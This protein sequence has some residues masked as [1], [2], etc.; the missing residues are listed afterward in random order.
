MEG[1]KVLSLS[2]IGSFLCNSL[3]C[4]GSCHSDKLYVTDNSLHGVECKRIS[5][6]VFIVNMNMLFFYFMRCKDQSYSKQ[7][8]FTLQRLGTGG[9]IW[10]G[11][12]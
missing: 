2:P 9:N 12:V 4:K 11:F 3:V 6:L 8:C 1:Y 10:P 7:L 5:L